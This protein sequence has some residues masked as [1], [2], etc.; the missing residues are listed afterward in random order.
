MIS[1][2][3]P[4]IPAPKGSKRALINRYTGRAALVDSCKRAKPWAA[5]IAAAARAA[6]GATIS[7][8]VSL[9]LQFLL[10]RP[11]STPKHV[12]HQIKKPDLDKLTRCVLDALTVAGVYHDDAQVTSKV[13]T[14]RFAIP[15][16][17]P[18]VAVVVVAGYV[19]WASLALGLSAP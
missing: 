6:R 18:G 19:D 7:D 1:F 14:K 10:P 3:V 2:F 13:A 11:K 5:E 4:G 15:P 8:P 17:V 12:E 9:I 16:E